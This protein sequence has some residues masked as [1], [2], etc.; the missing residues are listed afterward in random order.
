MALA[1]YISKD[2]CRLG[3][4]VRILTGTHKYRNSKIRRIS[5]DGTIGLRVTIESG[6]WIGMGAS[7]LPGVTVAQGCVIGAST[8]VTRPTVENGLYVGVPGVRIKSLSTEEDE[9]H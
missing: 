5:E 9:Q 1:R 2:Y 4:Y 7:V 3:P 6:C 8:L